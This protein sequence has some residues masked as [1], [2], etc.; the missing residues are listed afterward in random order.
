M[1]SI[2]V[3]SFQDRDNSL[4]GITRGLKCISEH[5]GQE[6][7][8]IDLTRCQWLQIGEITALAACL[9]GQ[10]LAGKSLVGKFDSSSDLYK[11]MQRM[12]FF[13][14]QKIMK[15]EG[16]MRHMADEKLLAITEIDETANT[17]DI[18]SRLRKIVTGK[19]EVDVSLA[20]ALDYAFGEI[21]D[22][23]LTHSYTPVR[24][25]V[26]AQYY[27]K[28]SFVEFCVA[29]CGIG[30][31]ESLR[32]NPLYADYDDAVLLIKAFEEGVGEDTEGMSDDARG[33]GCGFG[34]TFAARL[35]E[36]TAGDLWM[37]SNSVGVHLHGS[38]RRIVGGCGFPGTV[39]C[40]RIPSGVKVTEGDLMGTDSN[41]PYGWDPCDGFGDDDAILW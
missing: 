14:V 28:K 10:R 34:L 1:K 31:G 17:N 20:H 16:F 2:D 3:S 41:E 35:V 38:S 26:A 24:G 39:V 8:A 11:Y 29:D 40:V 22:N 12:N 9:R 19:T 18:P 4:F 33:Y 15:E 7:L 21:I 37:V 32:K 6:K 27:P 5:N 13:S 23:V 25:I 36:K 30:V